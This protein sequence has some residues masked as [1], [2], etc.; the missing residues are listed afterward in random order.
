MRIWWMLSLILMGPSVFA[1]TS[2]KTSCRILIQQEKL[3][4][5]KQQFQFLTPLKTK[6][7]CKALAQIHRKDF[8]SNKIRLKKVSFVWNKTHKSIP[9][10]AKAQSFRKNRK[11]KSSRVKTL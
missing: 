8:D 5:E 3:N 1:L 9:S 11:R 6:E 7:Q 10:L 4:G 2:T